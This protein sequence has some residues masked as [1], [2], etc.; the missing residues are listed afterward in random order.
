M[1]ITNAGHSGDTTGSGRPRSLLGTHNL[2]TKA[3]VVE[4]TDGPAVTVIDGQQVGQVQA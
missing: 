4:S 2:G 3:I 1:S